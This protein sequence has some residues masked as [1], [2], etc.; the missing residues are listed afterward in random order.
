M[1]VYSTS[2]K[3]CEYI[4]G[5]GLDLYVLHLIDFLFLSRLFP[6]IAIIDIANFG[7]EAVFL[8]SACIFE[9]EA[10]ELNS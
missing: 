8:W 10:L 6:L 1:G 7:V 2:S 3:V 9:E 4:C 5:L